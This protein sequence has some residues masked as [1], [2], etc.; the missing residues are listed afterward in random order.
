MTAEG[1]LLVK[2]YPN[3]NGWPVRICKRE[4]TGPSGLFPLLTWST[5]GKGSV[6]SAVD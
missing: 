6:E 1:H 4:S 2:S 5:K 3:G